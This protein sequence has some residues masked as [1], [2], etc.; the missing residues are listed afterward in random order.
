MGG[1]ALSGEGPG[2]GNGGRPEPGGIPVPGYTN[3]K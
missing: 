3:N 2:A 1:A